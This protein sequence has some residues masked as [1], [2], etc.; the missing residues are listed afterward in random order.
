MNLEKLV[1]SPST[2]E[3]DADAYLE[4]KWC[5]KSRDVVCT[6]TYLVLFVNS[7]KTKRANALGAIT[8]RT[9]VYA[10]KVIMVA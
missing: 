8:R 6:V 7:T 10:T 1:K 2:I 3:N 5:L 9:T 4:F